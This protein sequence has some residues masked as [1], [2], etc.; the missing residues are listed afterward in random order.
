MAYDKCSGIVA[1]L[2]LARGFS[3]LS[4]IWKMACDGNGVRV[5]LYA[6]R[7]SNILYM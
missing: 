6:Q 2:T 7:W 3:Q 1:T 5:H 4:Q